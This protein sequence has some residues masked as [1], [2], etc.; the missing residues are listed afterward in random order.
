M[1]VFKI[2]IFKKLTD[3]A[4]HHFF[5]FTVAYKIYSTPTHSLFSTDLDK[6]STQ[7]DDKQMSVGM[8]EC[9]CDN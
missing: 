4:P 3:I 7:R 1:S 8:C 2:S 9:V 6:S 5:R